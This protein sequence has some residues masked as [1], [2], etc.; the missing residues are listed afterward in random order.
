MQQKDEKRREIGSPIVE[1]RAPFR[2][3]HPR[4]ES[5]QLC[6]L[7]LSPAINAFG[8]TVTRILAVSAVV[9]PISKA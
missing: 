8:R 3:F 1:R 9:H 5:A 2:I 6:E 7:A 4:A